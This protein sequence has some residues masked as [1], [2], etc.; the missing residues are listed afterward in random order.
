LNNPDAKPLEQLLDLYDNYCDT[1]QVI[2]ETNNTFEVGDPR[3]NAR[4]F[5]FQVYTFISIGTNIPL[6]I[7]TMVTL[8]MKIDHDFIEIVY[9]VP[10]VSYA[11]VEIFSL[12]FSPAA[13]HNAVRK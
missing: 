4:E 2:R 9:S 3:F 7:F 13:I 10:E 11:M 1:I 5:C 8:Y 6:I 12:T